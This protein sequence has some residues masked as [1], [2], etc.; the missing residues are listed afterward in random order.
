MGRWTLNGRDGWVAMA[1]SAIRSRALSVIDRAEGTQSRPT[2]L[3]LRRTLTAPPAIQYRD[4][5]RPPPSRLGL[6]SSRLVPS[7][8]SGRSNEDIVQSMY[9]AVRAANAQARVPVSRV[10]CRRI[11]Q[12]TRRQRTGRIT[13]GQSSRAIASRNTQCSKSRECGHAASSSRT[14]AW[15]ARGRAEYRASRQGGCSACVQQHGT[16][17]IAHPPA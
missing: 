14:H 11:K 16:R 17:Y 5:R 8:G 9:G 6:P 4:K 12:G 13:F 15:T 2:V 3:T 7:V 10:S 1:A